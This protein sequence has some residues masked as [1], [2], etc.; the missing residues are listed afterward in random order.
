VASVHPQFTG[1]ELGN[2]VIGDTNPDT[3]AADLIFLALPPG[4]SGQL[5]AEIRVKQ[6]DC[7]IVDLGADHRLGSAEAWGNYYD[8]N[9]S[10][11]GQ[12]VYGLP[13]LHSQSTAISH[14]RQVANPGCYATAIALAFI[15]ALAHGL[16]DEST[17]NVVAAS[18]TSGAGK[19]LSESLLAT[20]VMGSMSPY[21]VGGLHQHIPEIEQTLNLVPGVVDAR[22]TFTPI[23]APMPR[24]IIATCN[25]AV[26]AGDLDTESVINVY[27]DYFSNSPF[28]TVLEQGVLPSTGSVVGSNNV[29]ISITIDPRTRQLIAVAVLDNLVK[30]AAGQAIQ[31][32][33]IMNGFEESLGLPVIGIM[34]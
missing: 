30:G 33:N 12:W 8:G 32:A 21:K 3:L 28:V 23:L 20:N 10:F 13:E 26:R 5:A 2:L 4:A 9:V 7:M 19:S 24:G 27:R 18:G 15:P 16:V 14:A 11:A 29:H 34:P 17:L 1:T 31:N 25:G 22:L 6:P